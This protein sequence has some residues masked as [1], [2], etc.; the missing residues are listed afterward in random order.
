MCVLIVCATLS[1]TFLIL[2]RNERNMITKY[3]GIHV[4]YSSFLSDFNDTRI[5]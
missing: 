1:V 2:R 5:F 3:I 4:K